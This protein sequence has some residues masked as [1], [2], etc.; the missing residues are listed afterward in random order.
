MAVD[1]TA[2]STPYTNHST[3]YFQKKST[4]YEEVYGTYEHHHENSL[5]KNG[6]DKASNKTPTTNINC[7][8]YYSNHVINNV[9]YGAHHFRNISASFEARHAPKNTTYISYSIIVGKSITNEKGVN[10]SEAN[11][12]YKFSGRKPWFL[13]PHPL[14]HRH[15]PKRPFPFPKEHPPKTIPHL[16]PPI[17]PTPLAP[18]SPEPVPPT[19][20]AP[21]SNDNSQDC[22]CSCHTTDNVACTCTCSTSPITNS[23]SSS[24]APSSPD[25]VYPPSTSSHC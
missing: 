3:S 24:G 21:T 15:F 1:I 16:P 25:E 20:R 11:E 8:R 7:T 4:S 10:V 19:P 6:L 13:R 9:S 17:T 2:R 18:T 5:Q 23:N 12:L 22:N 14:P